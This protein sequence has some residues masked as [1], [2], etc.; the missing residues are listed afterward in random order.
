MHLVL[1]INV[2]WLDANEDAVP[3]VWNALVPIT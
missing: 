2:C 1:P 3:L